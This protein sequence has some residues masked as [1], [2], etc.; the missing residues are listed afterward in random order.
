MTM[1]SFAD[2]SVGDTFELGSQTITGD[3]IVAF[4]R[5]FDPEW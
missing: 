3:E 2:F 1:R 5:Q 4:A